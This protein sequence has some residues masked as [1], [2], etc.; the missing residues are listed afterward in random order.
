MNLSTTI[1]TTDSSRC[2]ISLPPSCEY[3]DNKTNEL[4]ANWSNE[5]KKTPVL[6]FFT[7]DSF[8]MGVAQ[9]GILAPQIQAVYRIQ[10]EVMKEQCKK[11]SPSDNLCDR[12]NTLSLPDNFK[13]ELKGILSG[14]KE[15]LS[16]ESENFSLK[17]FSAIHNCT[18]IN[19]FIGEEIHPLTHLFFTRKHN[20]ASTMSD[21]PECI[22]MK[23]YP[24]FI[25]VISASNNCKLSLKVEKFGSTIFTKGISPSLYA[26]QTLERCRS[27]ED[28]E[29][30]IYGVQDPD[31]KPANSHIL[32]ASDYTGSS[33]YSFYG[34]GS[35]KYAK[36]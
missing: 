4:L 29:W 7:T 32:V 23:T 21:F 13:E 6:E 26:R 34:D 36:H 9:A 24:G 3:R 19:N 16:L 30:D 18:H 1:H 14:L 25:G 10:L 2:E 31:Y 28:I 27:L 22:E 12:V 11:T 8:K 20:I 17:N 15:T 5:D 33:S 35:Y